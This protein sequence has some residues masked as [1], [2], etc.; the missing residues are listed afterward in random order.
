M[1]KA[2]AC[3][4]PRGRGGLTPARRAD[5]QQ[6]TAARHG[7]PLSCDRRSGGPDRAYNVPSRT[8]CN[9][10]ASTTL[11][12]A[13]GD[14]F[15]GTK[16]ASGDLKQITD[17]LVGR[18]AGFA[19][20]SG[21]DEITVPMLAPGADGLISVVSNVVP[22]LM[23]ELVHKGRAGD[24][25]GAREL[26]ERVLPWLRAAFLETNPI[27]VKAALH[28]DA[29]ERSVSARDARRATR[30]GLAALVA[31]GALC[32]GR[33][34]AR[35][36]FVDRLLRAWTRRQAWRPPDAEESS[37]PPALERARCAPRSGE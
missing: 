7:R 30:R 32:R 31:V 1:K 3:R 17:I 22:R 21:A 4:S 18:P 13:R 12:L 2:I 8:G 27:P 10:D 33:A 14:T 24:A 11:E 26:H 25:S 19:V 5:V 36:D 20:L 34:G 29:S 35:A 6:A 37:T 23:R 9:I 28:D 16:E 15:V